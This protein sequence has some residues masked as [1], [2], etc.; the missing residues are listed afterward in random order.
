MSKPIKTVPKFSNENEELEFWEQHN[1]T[2]NCFPH[3]T[4]KIN[5]KMLD[6]FFMIKNCFY[7]PVA[8]FLRIGP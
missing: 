2:G 3:P 6:S 4:L 1:S 8:K 7:C 5:K